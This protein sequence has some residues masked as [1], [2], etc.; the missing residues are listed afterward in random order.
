MCCW[1]RRWRRDSEERPSSTGDACL[2]RFPGVSGRDFLWE[3]M[4]PVVGESEVLFC[5]VLF[6]FVLFPPDQ[7]TQDMLLV[8]CLVPHWRRPPPD[9]HRSSLHHF[10]AA[11]TKGK[12]SSNST[13]ISFNQHRVK[14][15][16]LEPFENF[17]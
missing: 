17:C 4:D 6:Y 1:R 16:G 15:D 8:N 2:S 12:H 14:I 10:P 13:E 3:T 5:F 7:V 11:D 9:C